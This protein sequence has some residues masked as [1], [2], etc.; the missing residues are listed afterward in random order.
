MTN[1][2]ELLELAFR[3]AAMPLPDAEGRLARIQWN[4]KTYG[5]GCMDTL[6]DFAEKARA[7]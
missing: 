2:A 7:Q 1:R 3:V 5:D 6:L 4:G